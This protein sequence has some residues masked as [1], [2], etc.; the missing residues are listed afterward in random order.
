MLTV[1]IKASLGKLQWDC[2]SKDHFP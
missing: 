1:A 2:K